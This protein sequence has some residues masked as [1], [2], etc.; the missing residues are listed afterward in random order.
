MYEDFT[1]KARCAYLT[2][3]C[4]G[5]S[6]RPDTPELAHALG[7]SML[8]MM[9][10]EEA[11][12]AQCLAAEL[13]ELSDE[14]RGRS[15]ATRLRLRMETIRRPISA[16]VAGVAALL[17]G[18]FIVNLGDTMRPDDWRN[19]TDLD[20]A[21]TDVADVSVPQEWLWAGRQFVT[22]GD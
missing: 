9:T 19:Y 7:K 14:A 22:E 12:E 18:F 20:A 1:K 16:Y 10:D 5:A 17:S 2:A 11:L 13:R 3:R 21:E 4:L 15:S 8:C 6:D